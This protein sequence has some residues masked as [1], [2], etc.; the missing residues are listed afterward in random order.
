MQ[1]F[2]NIIPDGSETNSEIVP[3]SSNA[4]SNS[5]TSNET[6]STSD[7]SNRIGNP[8]IHIDPP[9]D[10]PANENDGQNSNV[11]DNDEEIQI[12][13][14][15]ATLRPSLIN[16]EEILDLWA[17]NIPFYQRSRR[18]LTERPHRINT[19]ILSMNPRNVRRPNIKQN[20]RRLLYYTVEPNEGK[21]FIKELCFNNDGRLILSPYK[22]G[23]R[24]LSFNQDCEELSNVLPTHSYKD[25]I[26]PQKLHEVL[27]KPNQHQDIVVSTKFSPRAPIC[28]SGCLNGTISWYQPI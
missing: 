24:L 13:P 2:D 14:Y 27:I 5:D 16:T 9:E 3:Y 28:V 8:N 18:T 25:A 26:V 6:S 21:G 1:N 17:G 7:Q 22:C 12:I 20:S 11:P 4:S 15:Q 23:I 10:E 19:G